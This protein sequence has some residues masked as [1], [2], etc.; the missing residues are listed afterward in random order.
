MSLCYES[1][2]VKEV[3]TWFQCWWQK[4]KLDASAPQYSRYIVGK[5][6]DHKFCFSS[7]CMLKKWQQEVCVPLHSANLLGTS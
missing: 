6:S 7:S 1:L 3:G 4:V 5:I 2:A